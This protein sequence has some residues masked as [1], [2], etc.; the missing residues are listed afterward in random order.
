MSLR[1]AVFPGW[2]VN[3]G[4]VQAV[5]PVRTARIRFNPIDP[6]FHADPYPTYAQMRRDAPHLRAL[7]TLVLTRYADVVA[8]LKTRDLSVA[9]I[10]E[11]IERAARRLDVGDISEIS[12]FIRQSIVFTDNPAHLKLRRLVNAAYSPAML[13]AV[14]RTVDVQVSAL[15]DAID[16]RG[17]TADFIAD[18]ARPLPVNVLCA[19][20]RVPEARRA[21]IAEHIHM[22]RHLLD[23][24]LI[25]RDR[26]VRTRTSLRTLTSFFVDHLRT[27]GDD[28]GVIGALTIA[29]DD[30]D[31]LDEIDIAFACIMTFVAGTETTES[32]VGNLFDTLLAHPDALAALRDDRSLIDAA[33]D[34]SIRFETPLQ[35]TK[36][37]A[38]APQS[39]N[40]IDVRADEQIL[41]CLGAANR[42]PEAFDAPDTF[43]PDRR[44][45]PHV[46]FG[47]GMHACLGAA[48]A[49]MQAARS[50][51]YSLE[52][53]AHWRRTSPDVRWQ[54]H[55]VI[56]RGR[57]ALP[58]QFAKDG[59]A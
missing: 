27:I 1:G 45:P 15:L 44:G 41:L 5:E 51:A 59:V 32:L 52:R 16:A 42:D 10:P 50:V 43:R 6:A 49:R 11:T 53:Y 37:I 47:Y 56:L 46:G 58:I 39:I 28:D 30:G 26:L 38:R 36:R 21:W 34:E 9:L 48:L 13:T 8:A 54:T 29:R 55:S 40:G 17:G 24:G 14:E 22:V 2:P 20:M 23:P 35:M 7:G 3:G 4:A 25:N 57:G 18:F 31:R 19:W 33:V 12:R